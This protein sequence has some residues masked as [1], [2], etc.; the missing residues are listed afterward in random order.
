MLDEPQHFRRPFRENF[1]SELVDFIREHREMLARPSNRRRT[2]SMSP[3]RRTEMRRAFRAICQEM[4]KRYIELEQT[5]EEVDHLRNQI[6]EE[7]IMRGTPD[8]FD[9][10]M[11]CVFLYV[12]Q[13]LGLSYRPLARD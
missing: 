12:Q 5:F 13:I 1:R 10:R 9:R 6:F 11:R 4:K 7:E 2:A 3:E 8:N